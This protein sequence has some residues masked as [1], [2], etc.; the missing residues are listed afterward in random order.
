MQPKPK[1]NAYI[2]I[3]QIE[4]RTFLTFG[5]NIDDLIVILIC[6]ASIYW[7]CFGEFL[8]KEVLELSG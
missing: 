4:E 1:A 5:K 7:L 3:L 2:G 8:Q 6:S